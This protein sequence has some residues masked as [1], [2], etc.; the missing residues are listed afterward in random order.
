MDD[1]RA[2]LPAPREVP[3]TA[4]APATR[5]RLG[6]DLARGLAVFGMYAAHTGPDHRSQGWLLGWLVELTHG[7]A[8]V[9]FALLAGVSLAIGWGPPDAPGL[10][11]R[12]RRRTLLARALL[13]LVLGS[14]LTGLAAPVPVILAYYGAYYL[15]AWPFLG[16]SV[17][18]LGI[19]TIVLA[20][21]M[22][23]LSFV[24]RSALD[25]SGWGAAIDQH[26]PLERA[27]GEGFSDLFLTGVYPAVTWIPFL[28]AGIA[29]GRVDLDAP[30]VRRV[31]A[32]LALAMVI[33][34]HGATLVAFRWIPGL[35]A[36]IDAS[37]SPWW[38][39]MDWGG[40]PTGPH[41]DP[42]PFGTELYGVVGTDTPAWLWVS[43]PHS[44]TSF[45]VV[46]TLGV[47]ILT[48]LGCTRL[49]AA[50]PSWTRYLRPILAVG[51]MSLT[52]YLGHIV[53]LW[54]LPEE[55]YF[56]VGSIQITAS[57]IAGAMLFALAWLRFA[58]RGPA[59]WV[60]HALTVRLLRRGGGSAGAAE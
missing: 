9:L 51:S 18:A 28:T 10:D 14:L 27:C 26:D 60:V 46:G 23:Q 17:R 4:A 49:L 15:L 13:F 30:S 55:W 44:G 11:P 45:D 43:N 29:L 8:S 41:V 22:P 16:L 47:A 5:R 37:R 59:E 57:L 54:C 48:L 50:R 24:V 21:T 42:G 19:A 38:H 58:R 35:Q 6:V 2:T 36:A 20:A 32:P 25:A 3:A 1:P 34:A 33:G 56:P 12:P 7:R 52:A 39:T 40:G 53:V 31:L